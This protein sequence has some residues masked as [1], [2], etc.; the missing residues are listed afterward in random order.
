MMRNT[1]RRSRPTICYVA[2]FVRG[3][4]RRRYT[5]SI[6]NVRRP[7][8][9]NVMIKT[10]ML[11]RTCLEKIYQPMVPPIIQAMSRHNSFAGSDARRDGNKSQKSNHTIPN[12]RSPKITRYRM[13]CRTRSD[14]LLPQ[15]EKSHITLGFSCGARSAFKLKEKALLGKHAI[16]PSAASHCYAL[17]DTLA[18]LPNQKTR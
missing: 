12:N 4:A 17:R 3:V 10:V 8:I 9:R 7:R 2:P 15:E 16:A 18:C 5:S 13:I 6:T 1:P 11:S 14:K